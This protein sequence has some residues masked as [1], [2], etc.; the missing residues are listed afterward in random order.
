MREKTTLRLA[1]GKA[2]GFFYTVLASVVANLVF[3]YLLPHNVAPGSVA[4][5]K[6]EVAAIAALPPAPSPVIMAAAE[7]L[8]TAA[9]PPRATTAAAA[10]GFGPQPGPGSGGLY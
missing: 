2:A 9:E 7:P 10:P 5:A 1:F 8:P 3:A 6:R 4:A